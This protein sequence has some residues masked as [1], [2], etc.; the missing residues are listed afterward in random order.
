MLRWKLGDEVFWNGI[1]SYIQNPV[2]AYGFVRTPDFISK[3]E[4]TSGQSLTEFFSDWYKGQGYPNYQINATLLSNQVNLK[5]F[6]TSSHPSVSFFEMPV[7]VRIYGG[8]QDTLVVLNHQ[9]SGEE[10]NFTVP[11]S[12]DSIRFDPDREILAKSIVTYTATSAKPLISL[13]TI[14]I[15]PNP[16]SD[17]MVIGGFQKK[18]RFTI[19]DAMGRDIRT[20]DNELS[21]V[22]V[23]FQN[24]PSGLYLVRT[25]NEDGQKTLRILHE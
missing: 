19:M 17:H 10:F 13:S 24:L 7:P 22:S 20:Y 11:F 16:I 23:S 14:S 12:P 3:M 18:G 21:S 25:E 5:V 1:R 6:Q 8:G 2:Y 15:Q 9:L 4:Q